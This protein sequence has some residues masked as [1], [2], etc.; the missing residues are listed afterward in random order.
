MNAQ[1]GMMIYFK[2]ID[3]KIKIITE[4]PETYQY[5]SY[6]KGW[7]LEVIQDFDEYYTAK[8]LTQNQWHSGS[9]IAVHKDDCKR[10]RKRRKSKSNTY[11]PMIGSEGEYGTGYNSGK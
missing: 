11:G 7:I 1:K 2:G 10:L 4:R 5:E 6:K 3:M 9:V 8:L